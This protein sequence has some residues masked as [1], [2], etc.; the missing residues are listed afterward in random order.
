ML[1][2][3]S[4]RVK[5]IDRYRVASNVSVL[6]MIGVIAFLLH[7]LGDE[8]NDL[9]LQVEEL[10]TANSDLQIS[11][12]Q[13]LLYT[14]AL[15]AEVVELKVENE[16]LRTFRAK[17]TAYS[18][19][20]DRNG[21]NSSGDPSVTATGTRPRIGVA[22]VDPKKIPYGSR[23]LVPGYGEVTAEDTGGALRQYDGYAIDVFMDTYSEAMSF[24]VKYI[25]VKILDH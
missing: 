5:L 7:M 17:V 2:E 23:L 24:G 19:Y 25:D 10:R 22:A 18:P 14:E 11:L 15:E 12:T 1:V 4:V 3:S 6:L 9:N 20:D 21:I 16:K 13:A 8:F